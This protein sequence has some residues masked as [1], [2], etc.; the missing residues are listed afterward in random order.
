M[1]GNVE[2]SK[3]EVERIR[4]KALE[5][6]KAEQLTRIRAGVRELVETK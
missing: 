3:E 6:Q 4:V 2:L 1:E 5:Q